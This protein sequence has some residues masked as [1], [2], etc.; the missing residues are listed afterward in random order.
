MGEVYTGA[1]TNESSVDMVTLG[2]HTEPHL[3]D[4]I[5]TTSLA[6]P[7][8][9]QGTTGISQSDLVDLLNK[10]GYP[11]SHAENPDEYLRRCERTDIPVVSGPITFTPN[12]YGSYT[13]STTPEELYAEAK[14][15]RVAA[16]LNEVL[17]GGGLMVGNLAFWPEYFRGYTT[18]HGPGLVANALMDLSNIIVLCGGVS[19]PTLFGSYYGRR[20]R[21]LSSTADALREVMGDERLDEKESCEEQPSRFRL[22]R[23][24]GRRVLSN[25]LRGGTTDEQNGTSGEEEVL[26]PEV[27][28][29]E[30]TPVG[31]NYSRRNF[32][33]LNTVRS[34][35]T[36]RGYQTT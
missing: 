7:E 36:N 19:I 8:T 15:Y 4:V 11:A 27:L 5:N 6:D 33:T 23:E 22:A 21:E 1:T 28:D 2:V 20:F 34:L 35:I 26:T 12:K 17:A 9:N 24:I 30:G 31:A 16:R 10:N 3:P 13:P 32:I 25:V 18:Y 29:E 14:R